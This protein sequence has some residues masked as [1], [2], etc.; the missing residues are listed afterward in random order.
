MWKLKSIQQKPLWAAVVVVLLFVWLG[1]VLWAVMAG[2]LVYLVG[3]MVMVRREID[4]MHSQLDTVI[5]ELPSRLADDFAM[6]R[7]TDA[8]RAPLDDDRP[9]TFELSRPPV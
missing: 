4:D 6:K 3:S 7:R 1:D 5:S 2:V 8:V 9:P